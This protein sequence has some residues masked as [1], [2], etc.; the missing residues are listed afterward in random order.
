MFENIIENIKK[1]G[2]DEIR[3]MIIIRQAIGVYDRKHPNKH[4]TEEAHPT[5]SQNS[6]PLKIA[7]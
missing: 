1:N 3:N 6:L 5:F 2:S 7:K 4:Q